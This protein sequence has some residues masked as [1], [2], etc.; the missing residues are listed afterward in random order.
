MGVTTSPA[1]AAMVAA[2]AQVGWRQAAHALAGPL[3]PPAS[4]AA[5]APTAACT[6]RIAAAV[7]ERPVALAGAQRLPLRRR[8]PAA[9]L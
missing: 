1:A 4:S 8:V 6:R 7:A 5:A 2:V 3:K 9:S